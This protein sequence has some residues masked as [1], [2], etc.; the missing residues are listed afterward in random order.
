MSG[1]ATVLGP[2][3]EAPAVNLVSQGYNPGVGRIEPDFGAIAP[4]L[5]RFDFSATE[6]LFFAA[7]VTVVGFSNFT[8]LDIDFT[9][10]PAFSVD[11]PA[12]DVRTFTLDP[13]PFSGGDDFF[14][15]FAW[16]SVDAAST[17]LFRAVAGGDSIV[18]PE[19][20]SPSQI[21]LPAA[22]WFLLA[23]VAGLGAFGRKR[24]SSN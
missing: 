7:A 18:A 19:P 16:D 1:A 10:S 24:K 14:L 11:D 23:G 5:V 9:G 21:P 12:P 8:D 4:E 17:I 6:N 20:P 2:Y 3:G 22:G 13:V 15:S